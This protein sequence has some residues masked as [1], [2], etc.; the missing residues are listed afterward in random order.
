VRA[1]LTFADA[2]IP[3]LREAVMVR[4]GRLYCSTVL[5]LRSVP[6]TT[7][8]TPSGTPQQIAF[9]GGSTLLPQIPL[10]AAYR[11]SD[12]RNGVRYLV[13]SA[14]IT[15]ILARAKASGAQGASVSGG[16]GGALT[17]EGRWFKT[18]G[19][20][21]GRV[22]AASGS[23]GFS[24]AVKSDPGRTCTNLL[25][26]E[27]IALIIGLAGFAVLVAG[28]RAG[29]TPR[30]RLERR[31]RAGLRRREFFLEYQPIVK[32]ANAEWVGAEALLRWNHPRLGLVMPGKF[33]SE[34]EQTSVIGPLTEFIL[35]TAL[36]ELDEFPAGFRVNVNLA[37]HHTSLRSFPEDI[38][39]TLARNPTRLQVVLEITERGLVTGGNAVHCSLLGLRTKGVEF[40]VDDFGTE[41]SNLSLLQRFPFDYIKIDR[42]FIHR[43]AGRD[44][45]LI[46]GVSLL[47]DRLGASVVA[48]GV[49]EVEQHEALKEIGVAFA[50][51]F[52]FQRPLGIVEFERTYRRIADNPARMRH[53][54]HRDSQSVKG[55]PY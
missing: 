33:I 34:I 23:A 17:S 24:I 28:Y 32:S 30:Q 6:P 1:Q 54:S 12:A 18:T 11:R 29:F 52:L 2:F 46:E 25:V 36:A 42:R 9:V 47:A 37:P 44:R 31:V 4:E 35:A 40:A 3:Y 41:N 14:Y 45:Q 38:R 16:S 55:A 15:D 22:T 39:S 10:M 43:V 21:Q 13:E 27:T 51:G 5:G 7:Y 50:Q 20:A 49:E 53:H 48:E 26:T 8:P 19:P